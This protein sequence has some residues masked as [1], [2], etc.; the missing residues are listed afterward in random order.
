MPVSKQQKK[1]SLARVSSGLDNAETVVFANF[2][3]LTLGEATE[4]RRG[5]RDNSVS[6]MVAKKTLIKKALAE[7]GYKGEL[8]ELTG[9]LAIAWG[10]DQIAPAKF[11]ADFQKK[12]DKRIS[13]LG[14]VFEGEFK[15]KTAMLAIAS[16]PSREVLLSQIAYLLKSPIQMFAIAVSEVAKKKS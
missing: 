1:E 14:G 2:K 8:P 5:L 10:K 4:L 15:D 11:L 3:G 12:F 7:K 6:Y 16:I 9:E 13:I